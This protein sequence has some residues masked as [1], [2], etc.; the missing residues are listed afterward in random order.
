[1]PLSFVLKVSRPR[2]WLYVFGPYIVGAVAGASDRG[3]VWDWR[4]LLFA[5]YFLPPANLLIYGTNDIF[6]FE[7]DRLNEKKKG[8]ETLVQDDRRGVLLTL[9]LILNVPFV[10]AALF[11]TNALVPLA[12]FIFFSVF[13]SAPPIRAKSVPFLDS[14]FNVLYVFP[15]VLSFRLVSGTYPDFL[16]I[17]AAGLWTAAMHAYSA[18]PDIEAD[19]AAGV[20]T[21][22][23]SLGSRTTLI[24]CAVLFAAAAAIAFKYLG[25]LAPTLGAV[26]LLAVAVSLAQ[27]STERLFSIYRYFPLL[28]SFSGFLIFWYIAIQ[29]WF[30]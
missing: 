18:V 14:A 12:M 25:L 17:V 1:M 19:K 6:D 10:V 9:I 28:N 23:T 27:R 4:I 2:F 29:K 21:I 7:T 13:Y 26:Y 8:Y 3:F 5:I 24:F 20:S 16:P 30:L 22:A 15:A 11:I